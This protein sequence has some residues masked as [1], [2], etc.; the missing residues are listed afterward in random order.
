MYVKNMFEELYEFKISGNNVNI[1]KDTWCNIQKYA[2]SHKLFYVVYQGKIYRYTRAQTYMDRPTRFD[3]EIVPADEENVIEN[4]Y[5][6]EKESK[7]LLFLRYL[8]KY[9]LS[10]F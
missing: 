10:Q 3:F 6:K 7:K 8:I 5:V 9:Q 2:R 4:I 1:S